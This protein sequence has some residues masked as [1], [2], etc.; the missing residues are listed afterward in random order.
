MF[1]G[2]RRTDLSN[3]ETIDLAEIFLH[4]NVQNLRRIWPQ[5]ENISGEQKVCG[6][7]YLLFHI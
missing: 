1:F 7:K 5:N 6:Q 3:V 2:V 4:R